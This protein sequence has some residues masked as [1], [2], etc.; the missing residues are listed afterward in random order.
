MPEPTT[1][2]RF[3]REIDVRGH[4]YEIIATPK[5]PGWCA[6]VTGHGLVS[7]ATLFERAAV[8]DGVRYASPRDLVGAIRATAPT[9]EAALDEAAGALRAA[10]AAA[11][12]V[13]PAT[14]RR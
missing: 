6:R 10:F 4:R 5:G 12:W 3:V 1:G 9:A 14:D 13:D 2:F 8:V 11:S 7:R